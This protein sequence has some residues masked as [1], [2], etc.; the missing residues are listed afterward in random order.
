MCRSLPP[1]SLASEV[2]REEEDGD[3]VE[4]IEEKRLRPSSPSPPP[5]R[6]PAP[7]PPR[8]PDPA[9]A[10]GPEAA[11][12]PGTEAEVL[13]EHAASESLLLL[14]SARQGQG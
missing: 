12:V 14:S 2:K 13:E 8:A 11:E 1:H 10:P 5:A 4:I 9:P 3:E 6:V 7:P